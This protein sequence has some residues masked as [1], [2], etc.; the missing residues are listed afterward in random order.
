MQKLCSYKSRECLEFPSRRAY[1]PNMAKKLELNALL[2]NIFTPM[3]NRLKNK[4]K[5][6]T[7]YATEK[8]DSSSIDIPYLFHN[9]QYVEK[10]SKLI[11][12]NF[13]GKYRNKMVVYIFY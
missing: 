10:L 4:V 5:K 13:E 12:Y 1:S 3:K 11:V 2:Y 9:S 7:I 6:R 8:H